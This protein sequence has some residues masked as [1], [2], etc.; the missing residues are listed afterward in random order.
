VVKT[1]AHSAVS[2]AQLERK[3]QMHGFSGFIKNSGRKQN[4][5]AERKGRSTMFFEITQPV[6]YA[7]FFLDTRKWPPRAIENHLWSERGLLAKLRLQ[8][9]LSN[10]DTEPTTARRK[11]FKRSFYIFSVDISLKISRKEP[12]LKNRHEDRIGSLKDKLPST[13]ICE[14]TANR[15]RRLSISSPFSNFTETGLKLA[16]KDQ[17]NI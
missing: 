16:N 7:Q 9:S 10:N 1:Y 8:V 3:L 13:W 11:L 4:M 15:L 17:L 14:I 2:F 12:P 5:Y 6:L